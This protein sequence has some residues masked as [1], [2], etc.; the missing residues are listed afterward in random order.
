MSAWG[1]A[2]SP[3]P[4]FPAGPCHAPQSLEWTAGECL[5][6]SP[7]FCPLPPASVNPPLGIGPNGPCGGPGGPAAL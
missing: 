2:T 6:R 7:E 5:R 3:A 4:L 1:A